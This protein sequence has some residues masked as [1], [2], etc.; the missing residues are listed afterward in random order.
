MILLETQRLRLRRF[1]LDDVDRLVAL[2]SDPEVMRYITGGRPTPRETYVNTFLPHWF[3]IYEQQPQLGFWAV[4][5]WSGLE[6]IGWFHLRD[7]WMEPQYLEL[8]YR[9]G[10][11]AWGQGYATEG[12]RALLE[13]GFLRAGAQQI[14]ARTLLGNRASQRVMEKIGMRRTGEFLYPDNLGI[15]E[16]EDERRACKYEISRDEWLASRA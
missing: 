1:T 14:S 11:A 3:E 10:R 5:P 15:G 2:D 16:T 7:D 12:S 8:G 9:F 4:E 6:L 13:H